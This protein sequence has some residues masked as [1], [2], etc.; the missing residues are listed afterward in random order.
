M[1]VMVHTRGIQLSS[2]SQRGGARTV[3][4]TVPYETQEQED[5]ER[6]IVP[7]EALCPCSPGGSGG[8]GGP[9]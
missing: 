4:S 3:S 5:R 7:R 9:C 2:G 1:S 8:V 6:D